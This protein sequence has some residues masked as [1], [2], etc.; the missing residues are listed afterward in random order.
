[1]EFYGK[2][3]GFGKIGGGGSVSCGGERVPNHWDGTYFGGDPSNGPVELASTKSGFE[4]G[5]HHNF[6]AAY[7][8]GKVGHRIFCLCFDP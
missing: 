6:A 2:A 5:I 7:Y 1:V 3:V 8:A 4:E